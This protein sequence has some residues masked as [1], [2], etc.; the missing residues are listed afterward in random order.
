[1]LLQPIAH[2]QL[3]TPG[4][5][6]PAPGSRLPARVDVGDAVSIEYFGRRVPATVT[7]EPLVDP[8]RTRLRG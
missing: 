4:S 1:M 3:P 6:L 5:R 8:G 7:A 2:A